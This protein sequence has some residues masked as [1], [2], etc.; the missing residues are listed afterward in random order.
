MFQFDLLHRD[1]DTGARR[2]RLTTARSTAETPVF[3]PVGTLAT[4]KTLGSE[5]I[6]ALGAAIILG[7]AY[8]LSL[9]PGVETVEALGGLHRFMDYGGSI[10]TDSGGFQVFSLGSG[11]KVDE[12][13]VRFASPVDGSTRYFTPETVV[14]IQDRLGSDIAMPLDHCIRFG[15]PRREVAAAMERTVR[16]AV[17][18]KTEAERRGVCA[19]GIVQGGVEPDLRAD[20]AARLTQLDLPGYSIGGLS[21]GEGPE[22]MQAALEVT[23]PHLP[24][25]KPRY[26]MGVGTPPDMLEAIARGVDMFDCVIPTRNAR[27]AQALTRHGPVNMKNARHRTD[28]RPLDEACT[29]VTCRRYGRGYLRHLVT[30]KEILGLRLLT[31]HNIVFYLDLMHGAREAIEQNRYAAYRREVLETYAQGDD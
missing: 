19:F 13:G 29:C 31:I 27:N 6:E 23:T 28:E 21:V 4:V 24:E 8:H 3:M 15:A 12:E 25:A 14:E 9:R 22:R 7:N 18:T 11:V 16:W 26:L 5:D 30:A 17:R 20:C 10:L 1:P 2:G